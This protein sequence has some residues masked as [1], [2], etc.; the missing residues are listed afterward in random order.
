VIKGVQRGDEV[1]RLIELGVDGLVVSNHGGRQLDGVL[2][3]IEILPEV[4]DA[5]R[6]RVETFLDG[7]V[8]R[9]TDVVKALAL[10]ARAVLVGRPYLYGLAID[11]EDGV[12][13]VLEILR[14]E[15]DNA[16]ALMGVTSVSELGADDIRVQPA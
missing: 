5:A 10:G 13:A 1:E 3:S 9:G 4:L 12:S 2:A 6:G 15:L 14:S 8:R 7:G 16:F 11:G